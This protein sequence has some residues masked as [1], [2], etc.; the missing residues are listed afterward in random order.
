MSGEIVVAPN[1][2]RLGNAPHA[3]KLGDVLYVGARMAWDS[4]GGITRGDFSTQAHQVF[5]DVDSILREGGFSFDDVAMIHLYLKRH[6]DRAALVDIRTQYLPYSGWSGTAVET[7]LPHP[8]ALYAMEVVAGR[9]KQCFVSPAVHHVPDVAHAIKIGNTLYLQGQLGWDLT[10]KVSDDI[11]A[12]AQESYRNLNEILQIAGASWSDVV[13]VNSYL[14]RR[15]D[16]MKIE[17]VR[18]RYLTPGRWV[19]TDVVAPK[20]FPETTIE[21]E[22]VVAPG[23]E[24]IT[25]PE[26]YPYRDLPHAVKVGKIVYTGSVPGCDSNGN[27]VGRGDVT[28]QANQTFQNLRAVLKAAGASLAD[29]VKLNTYVARRTD[30]ESVARVQ[31]R[32][33]NQGTCIT[34]EV[35]VGL[36][37]LELLIEVDCLA[38][39]S[40]EGL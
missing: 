32:Y 9:P 40:Q 38:A 30:F 1:V 23:K 35:G 17:Q 27:I 21:V 5:R 15:E 31:A 25:A 34:T 3:V 36:L 10:G 39:A 29:V 26:V 19:A 13:K 24:L 6:Q 4:K 14:E 16:F 33:V 11:V 7:A 18:K 20:V 8:E 12:Q 22:L 28:A 2:F 37:D